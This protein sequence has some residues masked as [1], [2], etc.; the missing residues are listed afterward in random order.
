MAANH[1]VDMA[2]S[3]ADRTAER[4]ATVP[5]IRRAP[6]QRLEQFMLPDFLDTDTCAA[7]IE[8]IDR[9]VH[10]STIADPNGDNAF[11][12]STT[13]DL[14]H[15]DPL[16]RS[17]N[18]RLHDLTGIPLAY[19]EPLQGQRYD[20]GQ[21]FKA[22]TDYF[23]PG[24]SDW[25]TYCAIPGQRSWTLMIYLNQPAAG[26]AT[27]FLATGKLHQPETGR[28]LA[29]N[30]V[31]ADGAPN[32]DTLHHGMKVRKGRKYIITKWF[33][34]RPWPWGPGELD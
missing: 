8:R 30:N 33:R 22:H 21:E 12:T 9:D 26:G 10:P 15:R 14:D 2:S 16:V 7:L 29:W 5:S 6:T 19:G 1:F 34:E 28:L 31:G 4:L 17:V 25:E 18:I 32:P 13:C 23:D 20:V 3:S 24:G 27:R 11:R